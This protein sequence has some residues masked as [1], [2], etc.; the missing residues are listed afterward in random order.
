MSMIFSISLVFIVVGVVTRQSDAQAVKAVVGVW[1]LD[2]AVTDASKNGHDGEIKGIPQWVAGQ[3]GSKALD[4]LGKDGN[5]VLIPHEASLNLTKFTMT[6]WVKVRG[7]V[8]AHQMVVAKTAGWDLESYV[9]WLSAGIGMPYVSIVINKSWRNLPGKTVLFDDEWHHLAGTY[10]MS[11]MRL[12]VDG[13]LD[14][15]MPLNE[16]P[17]A[18]DGPLAIS[19]DQVEL[20]GAQVVNGAVDDVG[21]FSDA[22]DEKEIKNIMEVGL[23][24]VLGLTAVSPKGKLAVAWGKIKAEN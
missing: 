3:F 19:A 1:P 23:L 5:F 6:A 4:F 16:K 15:E 7:D 10:D 22:L 11:N 8:G 17:V 21:L 9:L 20:G 24:E 2:G 13:A 12:Y 18:N 14:A